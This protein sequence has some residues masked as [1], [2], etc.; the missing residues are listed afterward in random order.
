MGEPEEFDPPSDVVERVIAVLCL[1]AEAIQGGAKITR[2][3]TTFNKRKT[4]HENRQF[5]ETVWD[6]FTERHIDA[7]VKGT[8]FEHGK[9]CQVFHQQ[10]STDVLSLVTRVFCVT[11]YSSDSQMKLSGGL[12][13]MVIEA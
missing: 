10:S 1:S 2:R 3:L 6:T 5:C 8:H 13:T 11:L 9:I 12:V 4:G 7:S